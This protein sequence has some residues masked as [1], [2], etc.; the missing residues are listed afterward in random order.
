M[1]LLIQKF[2]IQSLATIDF[3]LKIRNRPFAFLFHKSLASELFH[4]SCIYK[5]RALSCVFKYQFIITF[6]SM[7]KPNEVIISVSGF[8]QLA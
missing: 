8:L 3:Q 2:R 1:E 6:L 7:V 5:S 4:R